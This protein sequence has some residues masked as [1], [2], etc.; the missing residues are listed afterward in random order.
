[1]TIL[2]ELFDE[3]LVHGNDDWVDASEVVSIIITI[4]EIPHTEKE[5]IRLL[6]FELIRKVV[7]EGY[8][9]IGSVQKGGFKKWGFSMEESLQKVERDWKELGN[10]P[11]LGQI[12][13]LCNTEEGN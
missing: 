10:N 9:V 13:W 4:E 11:G 6:T 5:K 7:E 3:L 12:C 2:K 8:M 1:M